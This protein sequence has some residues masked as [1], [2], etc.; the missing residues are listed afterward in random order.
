M[1]KMI[2]NLTLLCT[3]SG[4]IFLTILFSILDLAVGGIIFSVLSLISGLTCTIGTL[5]CSCI[6]GN[7][8]RS[9]PNNEAYKSCTRAVNVCK[10]SAA[11]ALILVVVSFIVGIIFGIIIASDSTTS[12]VQ[13]F[14][15]IIILIGIAGLAADVALIVGF[16]FSIARLNYFKDNKDSIS[17]GGSNPSATVDFSKTY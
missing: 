10:I 1:N 15:I 5:V 9:E 8:I 3:F 17:T 6:V 2:R 7:I 12:S 13:T 14:S 16:S 11:A 4:L